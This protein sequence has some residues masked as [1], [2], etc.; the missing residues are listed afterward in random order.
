M[1]IGRLIIKCQLS[2]LQTPRLQEKQDSNIKHKAGHDTCFKVNPA[3]KGVGGKKG[4][5]IVLTVF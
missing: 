5:G 2:L 1:E 3:L 4:E